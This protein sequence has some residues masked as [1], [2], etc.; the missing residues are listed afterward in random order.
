MDQDATA[1]LTLLKDEQTRTSDRMHRDARRQH[2]LKQASLMLGT[3]IHPDEVRTWLGQKYI[4][5]QVRIKTV[6]S[7]LVAV[8]ALA[9][10]AQA[11]PLASLSE[12][13]PAR[14]YDQRWESSVRSCAAAVA[15]ITERP[16]IYQVGFAGTVHH[17]TTN[18][19][20][21]LMVTCL[22]LKGML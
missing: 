15:R 18:R 13:S 9:T 6:A 4:T 19:Q 3:G 16:V 7:A 5:L 8:L 20:E 22:E 14:A 21:H 1:L 12:P 2:A 10:V 11:A 17:Y